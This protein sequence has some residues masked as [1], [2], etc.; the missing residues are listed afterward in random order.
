MKLLLENWRGFLAEENIDLPQ[1]A[2]DQ[3]PEENIQD[4]AAEL[5]ERM[6]KHEES[7]SFHAKNANHNTWSWLDM[8]ASKKWRDNPEKRV[9][10]GN[11]W[12]SVFDISV[13]HQYW[14]SPSPETGITPL[15]ELS[16]IDPALGKEIFPFLNELEN[17][18]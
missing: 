1:A 7:L 3:A 9:S 4:R 18:K 10:R 17:K 8:F 12:L 11:R 16:Q 14:D 5:A 6:K 2:A 15:Q 13:W